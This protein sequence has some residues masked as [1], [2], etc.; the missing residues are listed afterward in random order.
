MINFYPALFLPLLLFADIAEDVLEKYPNPVFF[1]TGVRRCVNLAR[2]LNAEFLEIYAIDEEEIFIDHSKY[3]FPMFFREKERK[4]QLYEIYHGDPSKDLAGYLLGISQSITFLLSSYIP[5]PDFPQKHNSILEELEQIKNHPIHT[6]TIL[7]DNIHLAAT[8]AFGM[9]TLKEIQQK[10]LEINPN[11]Q[12]SY[13]TGGH[14]EKE[15][16]AVLVAHLKF[17][18]L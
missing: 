17:L 16:N 4:T 8:S 18:C 12:F 3:I 9:V 11:Y 6:H 10:L 1:G 13:E 5:E 2:A 7:I 14:L 15:E